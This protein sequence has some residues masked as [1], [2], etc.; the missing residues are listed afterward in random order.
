MIYSFDPS[1]FYDFNCLP[2]NIRVKVLHLV[3]YNQNFQVQRA[4][5]S[6]SICFGSSQHLIRR[7]TRYNSKSFYLNHGLNIERS[8]NPIALSA[9]E[10]FAV[11]YAGNL[12]NKYVDWGLIEEMLRG[13]PSITFYFAGSL[14]NESK[15]KTLLQFSN[16]ILSSILIS[17]FY[18]SF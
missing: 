15:R 1:V 5:S 10:G 14:N 17:L 9:R 2:L 12:D 7:L 8:D 11:G 4:A 16:V 18:N 3:D 6:A 13:H